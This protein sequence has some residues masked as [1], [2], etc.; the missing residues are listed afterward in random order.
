MRACARVAQSPNGPAMTNP[1]RQRLRNRQPACPGIRCEYNQRN[2]LCPTP[3]R[4][5]SAVNATGSSEWYSDNYVP[6]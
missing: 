1:Q 5:I 2:L 4:R 6:Y 3:T